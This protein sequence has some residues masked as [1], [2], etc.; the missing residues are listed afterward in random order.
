VNATNQIAAAGGTGTSYFASSE[1]QLLA[2]MAE[3]MA[4]PADTNDGVDDD[5]NGCIDDGWAA[6]SM[7]VLAPASPSVAVPGQAV[8]FTFEARNDGPTNADAQVRLANVETPGAFVFPVSFEGP[9]GWTCAG[10]TCTNAEF[11][12]GE[13]ATFT[14]TAT[15][16]EAAADG[17]T[18]GFTL[19][20]A[21]IEY[22]SDPTGDD[23][24]AASYVTVV[25]KT[26]P[27]ITWPAPGAIQYGT[28]LGDAQLN[29]TADTEGSFAYGPPAGTILPVGV[30]T[31]TVDFAPSNP[32]R[33]NAASASVSITVEKAT[34]NVMLGTL[35]QQYTGG[36]LTPT[37]TTT[38]PGLAVVW[39]GAP[40]TAV[41]SYG[42]TATVDDPNYVGVASATF[43]ITRAAAT[44]TL[45]DLTQVYTGSPLVPSATTSPPGLAI[46]WTGAPTTDAGSYPVTASVD[47]PNYEGTASGTFVIAK[48]EAIV[49]LGDLVQTYTGSPLTPS[50]TTSPAGRRLVWTGTPDTNAGSYPVTATVDDPN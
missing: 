10:D 11:A 25:L 24:E 6:L 15:I 3:I 7:S 1:A 49:T 40:A 8:T 19:A 2:A 18:P 21:P 48:A 41:G 43:V 4:I 32:E 5:C 23:N 13:T 37:V 20:V 44:V 34:A 17:A 46:V 47:D 42:V 31:L 27:V 36:P 39:S 16:S 28:A 22:V 50:A 12:V 14:V 29:A 45:G 9:A 33:Y 35:T 26:T 38:P 30:H